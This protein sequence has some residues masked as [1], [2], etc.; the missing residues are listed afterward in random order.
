MELETA[1]LKSQLKIFQKIDTFLN[2]EK[3]ES[4]SNEAY[5]K[6]ESA[7]G[8]NRRLKNNLNDTQTNIV[9]L[10]AELTQIRNQYESKCSEL[11]D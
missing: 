11:H 4:H 8:E 3:E 6:L 10:R 2:K 9:L 1:Q 5:K 7:V